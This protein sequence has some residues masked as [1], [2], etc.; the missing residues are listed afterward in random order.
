MSS[1]KPKAVDFN[2]Q[3]QIILETARSVISMGR[4]GQIDTRTWQQRFFGLTFPI[5]SRGKR[6]H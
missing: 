4:L 3:W 6:R 2:E 5:D 1:L